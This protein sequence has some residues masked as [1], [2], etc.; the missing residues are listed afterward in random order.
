M[1]KNKAID[2]TA[3]KTFF[4]PS[5]GLRFFWVVIPLPAVVKKVADELNGKTMS[6]AEAVAKIQSAAQG[7]GE[8]VVEEDCIQLFSWSLK[9]I[10]D[11][12][13]P[14]HALRIIRYK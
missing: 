3:V 12:N 6:L 5:S 11:H 13:R 14:L 9:D 1:S 2:L 7:L 4:D 10:A 8:V